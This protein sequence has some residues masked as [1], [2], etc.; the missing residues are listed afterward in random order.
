MCDLV[1]TVS[2]CIYKNE[3]KKIDSLKMKIQIER[4]EEVENRLKQEYK[5]LVLKVV[6]YKADAAKLQRVLDAN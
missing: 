5:N 4:D 1:Q 2:V 6:R 3:G